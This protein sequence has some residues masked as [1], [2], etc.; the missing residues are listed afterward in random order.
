MDTTTTVFE[1]TDNCFYAAGF[2]YAG[3]I[4]HIGY[5]R[6]GYYIV[7]MDGEAFVDDERYQDL[8]EA[9]S[10]AKRMIARR[11]NDRRHRGN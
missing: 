10:E 6:Y 3:A 2:E 5:D 4:A 7:V 1:L 8:D 11:W 9:I